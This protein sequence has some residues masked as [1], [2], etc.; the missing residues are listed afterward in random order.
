[1]SDQP[2]SR[3]LWEL[4]QQILPGG[5]NSPVRAFRAVGGQPFFVQ[6][7]HGS[8]IED[9]DGRSFIDYVM[10]WGPMILGHAYPPVLKKIAETLKNGTSFGI[11]NPLE[12]RLARLVCDLVPSIEMVRMVN[13][14]TEAT[15]SAIRL[16][17]ALTGRSK[18]IKCIGCYHGHVDSLL[19]Q[20][21]SGAATLGTP[22]SAGIPPSFAR[23]T[24]P[25]QYN[26]LRAVEQ[27]FS[28]FPGEIAAIILEPVVGNAGV[29]LPQPGYLEAL[30][31]ITLR[32][33]ALLIF[34]EV[35][36][37]FRLA[38]GGAQERF[39]VTPDLTCLGK[40][41]GGGLPVGALGGPSDLMSQIA[42]SGPV[43]Q[44]GTLSGNP[45]AMAAGIATLEA[46]QQ[47]GLYQRLENAT[48][49][50]VQGITEAAQVHSIPVCPRQIGSMFSI[51]F[52][53]RQV[54]DFPSAATSDT[55]RF[56]RYFHFM[57][58]HGIYF[59]PSPYEA[60]FLSLAHTDEDLQTTIKAAQAFFASEAAAHQGS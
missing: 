7:A 28:D 4:S 60:G 2:T 48:Q 19:V 56:Q 52:T 24:I 30:R 5:V 11:P 9:V 17:R 38:P 36:T 13:S 39:A 22:D 44:A 59:A 43:Y 57:L 37:G 8:R 42:P 45:L 12:L 16:A 46:L 10:S 41:I 35:M 51:F 53:D 27:A 14:G 23:E 20:A 34:D 55:A 49:T 25:V 40:I 33:G 58:D 29:I 21:G 31:A 54:V 15:M 26:D 50:L 18:V 6:R 3:K 47:P 1:M 32:H